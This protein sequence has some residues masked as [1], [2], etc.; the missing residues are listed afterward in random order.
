MAALPEAQAEL[1]AHLQGE[2][3]G[4]LLTA[5]NLGELLGA[6]EEPGWELLFIDGGLVELE[7]LDLVETLHHVREEL[8]PILL[9][10]EAPSAD[11]VVAAQ[12]AG[13]AHLMVKPFALDEDFSRLLEGVLGL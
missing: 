12:E 4:K 13:V 6:L 5:S 1:A 2:G 7:G 9:A 3:Y 11:D 8:P 10:L